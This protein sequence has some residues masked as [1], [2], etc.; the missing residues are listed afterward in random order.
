M[1]VGIAL[2]AADY[3]I[4]GIHRLEKIFGGR[5]PA[6]VVADFVHIALVDNAR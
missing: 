5:I 1:A 3:R 2:T 4:K 6:A